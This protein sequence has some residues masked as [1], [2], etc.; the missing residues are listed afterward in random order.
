[1]KTVIINASPRKNMNTAQL[2]KEAKKGAESVGAE[3]EYIDLYDL[4]YTGC[5][6]CL[7]CKRKGAERNKCY[8]QDDLSPLIDRILKADNL[9]IGSPIYF[10]QPTAQLRALMERLLCC[11][12]SYDSEGEGS[13]YEGKLNLGFIYT[14]NATK[15]YYEGGMRQSLQAQDMVIKW[16]L[17]GD[18]RYY[19]SLDTLQV[20][21]YSKYSM[22]AFD[23]E[24][25]K[26]QHEEQ[27][28]IDLQEAFRMGAE[29]SR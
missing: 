6:S 12:M 7:A 21:D 15:D 13:Y 28:P 20:R 10:G 26:K 3:T 1:M 4:S 24:E 9:I 16:L 5:R 14:M 11:V 19:A 25:K 29:M 23:P 22:G 8:W 18:V 2:L 27:F 17:H